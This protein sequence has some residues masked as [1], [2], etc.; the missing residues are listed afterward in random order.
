[1]ARQ[2]IEEKILKFIPVGFLAFPEA[3]LTILRDKPW[4]STN[5]DRKLKDHP[6]KSQ[7]VAIVKKYPDIFVRVDFALVFEHDELEE[8]DV[9]KIWRRS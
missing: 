2:T 1:M 9:G 6:S 3:Y 7:I 5:R 4:T 8:R